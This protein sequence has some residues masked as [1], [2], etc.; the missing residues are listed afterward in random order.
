MMN[1]K[2]A[3]RLIHL[4]RLVVN[5]KKKD[6]NFDRKGPTV[7]N[8]RRRLEDFCIVYQTIHKIEIQK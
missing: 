7:K 4:R 8:P 5:D 6:M 2:T 3:T 1:I